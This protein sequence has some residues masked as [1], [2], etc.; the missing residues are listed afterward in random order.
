MEGLGLVEALAV[1]STHHVGVRV[2][3]STPKGAIPVLAIARVA[4]SKFITC[5][6]LDL[7]DL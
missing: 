2:A 3:L 5:K 4:R 6:L 7:E 1:E